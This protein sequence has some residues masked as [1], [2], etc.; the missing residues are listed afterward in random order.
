MWDQLIKSLTTVAPKTAQ[1]LPAEEFVILNPKTTCLRD[2][3]FLT[4][5]GQEFGSGLDLELSLGPVRVRFSAYEWK[6]LEAVVLALAEE[7]PE[8]LVSF[9][10]EPF[11]FEG[12]LAQ[13]PVNELSSW[14]DLWG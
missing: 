14:F 4:G 10:C 11:W 13:L 6:E 7:M 5:E 8:T 3:I 1:V 9:D 12:P 2:K